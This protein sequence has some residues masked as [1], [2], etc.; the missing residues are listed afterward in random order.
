MNFHEV[1]GH[2]SILVVFL[3]GIISFF[4]PCVLPL[5][6]LYM[7][8]LA[9]NQHGETQKRKIVFL[10][11]ICF[12]F[13]IFTAILLLN[14]SFSVFSL[15]FQ[16][17]SVLFTRIGGILIAMLGLHQIGF[18]KYNILEKTF[19]IKPR[20]RLGTGFLG[21]YVM[22]FSFSFAWTPCI[23]PALSS[24][25][26]LAS[27]SS[28]F[29][30]SSGLV[31]I[32]A[33]GLGLPFLLLGMFTN[34]ALSWIAKHKNAMNYTTK[35]GGVLLLL[36]G[37]MMFTGKFNL[38]S[39][40]LSSPSISEGTNGDSSIPTTKDVQ[41]LDQNGKLVKL[42][43]YEGK[44]VFLN[45]WATWCPACVSELAAIQDLYEAYK[46]NEE[47]VIL[48][49]V[50]PGGQEKGQDGILA[51]MSEKGL[52]FPVLFDDGMIYSRFRIQTMP[53]TYIFN[54]EGSIEGYVKGAMTRSIM[55]NVI[56]KTL[57]K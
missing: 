27:S 49:V 15:F 11:T 40:Y 26:I 9:K 48:S 21:A 20:K 53:S 24:I 31:I 37:L 38:F 28:N 10:Y 14:A 42:S 51:Y 18:I 3:E 29:W 45:F 32:Y 13:G 23:G 57:K 46:G 19:H 52:T 54:R 5:L 25:L 30:T 36:V 2:I 43:D 39:N 22:G 1:V 41:A 34:A 44:V 8:Y 16:N 33:L 35:L 12:V 50:L 55:E 4:S 7:G 47:V 17:H 56:Q 6:P